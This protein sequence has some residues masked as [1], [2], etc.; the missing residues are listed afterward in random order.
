MVSSCCK[1]TRGFI[2]SN[3]TQFRSPPV[4]LIE[5][6]VRLKVI[7]TGYIGVAIGA[8]NLGMKPQKS[9]LFPYALQPAP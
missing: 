4:I 9:E 3:G 5:A 7:K 1:S 8:T 6:G 2:T